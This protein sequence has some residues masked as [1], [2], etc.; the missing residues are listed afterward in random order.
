VERIASNC[1]WNEGPVW[2]GD[3]A[4]PCGATS[5]QPHDALGRAVRRVSVFRKPSNNANGSLRDR[6]GRLLTCEHDTPAGN[7][8]Q[9]DSSSP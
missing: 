1:R 4:P 8:H 2:F 9:Y 6:R 5:Q 3:G 7:A